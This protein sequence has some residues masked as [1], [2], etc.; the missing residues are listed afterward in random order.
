MIINFFIL[1]ILI[2]KLILIKIYDF[3]N[4]ENFDATYDK[5]KQYKESP[6][7]DQDQV[8]YKSRQ[9]FKK[10]P[11]S[12]DKEAPDDNENVP[13]TEELEQTITENGKT[14]IT[15][16]KQTCDKFDSSIIYKKKKWCF[17]PKKDYGDISVFFEEPDTCIIDSNKNI[18]TGFNQ[19]NLVGDIT[20]KIGPYNLNGSDTDRLNKSYSK[21]YIARGNEINV[22][23]SPPIIVK[24]NPSS[25]KVV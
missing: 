17:P 22:E 14:I 25:V 13:F 21:D 8:K 23:N 1:I 4:P 24:C 11:P 6:A 3:L 10:P 12:I 16:K 9:Q 2:L 15:Q 19:K 7:A 18:I 5:Y 20:F